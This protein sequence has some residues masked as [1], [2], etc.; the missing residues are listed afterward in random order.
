VTASHVC[1]LDSIPAA[2]RSD[3]IELLARA[4]VSVV[5]L[6][7]SNLYSH[8]RS[9]AVGARRGVTR[10]REL[11]DGGVKVAFGTDNIRDP[12]NPY[13]G[14]DL[15]LNAILAA[16]TCGMVTVD[17]FR[18][19]IAMHSTVPAEV[20]GLNVPTLH[21]GSV[22]DLVVIEATAMSE[23]LDGRRTAL[24]VL[25]RGRLVASASVNRTSTRLS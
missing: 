5:A 12:F 20:M 6:P 11:I 24:A 17:D 14:A 25:K 22:A 4:Q 1:A 19:V 7:A 8:G 3:V 2:S 13:L 18:S 23:L 9:D 21:E 15:L 10:V 16:T